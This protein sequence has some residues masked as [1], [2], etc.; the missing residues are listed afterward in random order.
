MNKEK[1]QDIIAD[2][3]FTLQEQY[4]R[5]QRLKDVYATAVIKE[6]V[7][8]VY[9]LGIEFAHQAA[10]YYSIGTFR[11]AL[12]LLSQPPSVVLESKVSDIKRAIKEMRMEMETQDRIR[13]N[14]MERN[15]GDVK[16]KVNKIEE[17]V[18]GN[19]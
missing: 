16:D 9:R 19:G 1:T 7:A 15:L 18:E 11:R 12:Y 4:S 13:L 2:M 8:V 10:L 6:H 5:I 17:S 3:L 14:N